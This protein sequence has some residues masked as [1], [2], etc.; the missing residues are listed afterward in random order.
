MNILTRRA[1]LLP[2]FL[3]LALPGCDVFS[4]IGRT[5]SLR[6]LP[7][8]SEVAATIRTL[9]DVRS[10]EPTHPTPVASVTS[11]A[12]ATPAPRF[13]QLY[14]NATQAGA[15]LELKDTAQGQH[16]LHLYCLWLNHAPS[17]QEQAETRALINEIYDALHERFHEV[18]PRSESQEQRRGPFQR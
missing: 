10:V 14:C 5:A 9:P 11:G 16:I 15:V 12:S 6:S 18:P 2:L 7:P 4:V 13:D 8:V 3:A 1:S 17:L